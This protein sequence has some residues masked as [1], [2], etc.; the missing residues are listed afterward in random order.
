MSSPISYDLQ[1]QGGGIVLSTAT[2]SNATGNFR[3]IQVV[4][5]TVLAT[6]TSD[7]IANEDDLAGITLPAG[8]GIGGRFSFVD[9]ASGT[10]IAYYA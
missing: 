3:W 1:G 4:N 10:V 8:L 6:L 5:D 7:N 2:Q 9:V